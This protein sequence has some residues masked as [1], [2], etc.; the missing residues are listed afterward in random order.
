MPITR[1]R[2]SKVSQL[3]YGAISQQQVE[4]R[5]AFQRRFE[6]AVKLKAK[7]RKLLYKEWRQEIGDIAARETA[8]Y[9]ESFLKG[10][11]PRTRERPK[12]FVNLNTIASTTQS[13]TPQ[14][15]LNV[16]MQSSLL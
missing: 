5:I 12:W 11:N 10:D 2:K 4:T 1:W 8:M 6:K 7:D 9:V 15:K 13:I 3:N 16:S 14:E